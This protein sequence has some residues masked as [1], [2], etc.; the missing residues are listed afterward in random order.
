M[1]CGYDD[2]HNTV[3]KYCWQAL[4]AVN[5]STNP[6]LDNIKASI[7]ATLD[8]LSALTNGL[9]SLSNYI[10]FFSSIIIAQLV[11]CFAFVS[12]GNSLLIETSHPHLSSMS[13]SYIS[14]DFLFFSF[15]VQPCFLQTIHFGPDF[16]FC[17][18]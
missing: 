2:L 18:G 9:A 11:F 15:P 8:E 10:Q 7:H 12:S 16:I 3:H 4:N 13:K 1:L 5:H 17:W 6:F 14:L